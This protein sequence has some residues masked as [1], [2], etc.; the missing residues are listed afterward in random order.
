MYNS[1]LPNNSVYSIAMEDNGDVWIGTGGGG[2]AK[3]DGYNWEVFDHTN[4]KLPK[5]FV[6]TVTIDDENTKWIG[7]WKGGIA[8][9]K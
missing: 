8:K 6:Y 2:L 4:S 5:D 7:T 1:G 9:F 3:F